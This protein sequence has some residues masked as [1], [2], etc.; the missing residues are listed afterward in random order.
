MIDNWG[1]FCVFSKQ[2]RKSNT[3]EN[4]RASSNAVFGVLKMKISQYKEP[5]VYVIF[6]F[7]IEE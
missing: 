7:L 1:K 2:E 5:N 3:E 6:Q 4:I